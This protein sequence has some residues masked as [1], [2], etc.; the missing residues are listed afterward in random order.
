MDFIVKEIRQRF[1][2][3]GARFLGAQVDLIRDIYFE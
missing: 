1:L 3:C 2:N